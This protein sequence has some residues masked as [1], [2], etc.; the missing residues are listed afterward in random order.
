[1]RDGEIRLTKVIGILDGY[2]Q[3]I[4][5]L[6]G[7]GDNPISLMPMKILRDKAAE[8][9]GSLEQIVKMQ[10]NEFRLGIFVLASIGSGSLLKEGTHLRQLAYPAKGSASYKH[11]IS[12]SSSNRSDTI[13]EENHDR[14]MFL[15][16]LLTNHP[17]RLAH[18][19]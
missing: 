17:P 5:T 1:M 12:P 4:D 15:L 10:F 16:V 8:V 19:H 9:C 18:D 2:L 7:K 3:W 14:A 6:Q 11:L 13:A